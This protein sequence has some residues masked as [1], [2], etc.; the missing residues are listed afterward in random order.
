VNTNDFRLN[1]FALRSA[2]NDVNPGGTGAQPLLALLGF[3]VASLSG[4]E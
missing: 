2:V 1:L 3:K 4:L